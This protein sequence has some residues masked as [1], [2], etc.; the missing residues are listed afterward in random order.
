[1]KHLLT[2]S[3]ERPYQCSECG[4]PFISSASLKLHK[5]MHSDDKPYQ[6]HTVRNVSIILLT[7]KPMSGFTP[8]RNRTCAPTAG[9]ALLDHM[10]SKFIREFTQEKDR[11]PAVIVGRVFIS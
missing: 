1:M 5:K 9:R 6:C 7:G 3:N 4:K 10:L 11:I 2:H 8:E